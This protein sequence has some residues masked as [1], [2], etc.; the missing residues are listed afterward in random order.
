MNGKPAAGA[1]VT[2]L[3]A[4]TDPAANTNAGKFFCFQLKRWE[5]GLAMLLLSNDADLKAVA[6]QELARPTDDNQRI[7]VGDSWFAMTK[8]GG[9][10]SEKYAMM[11]RAQHWYITAKGISGV[12]KERITQ[13]LAEIDKALPLDPDN[14]DYDSLTPTQWDKL[15]GQI[16]VVQVRVDRSGP[17]MTLKPGERIRVVPHPSDTW[18]CQSWVGMT[19]TTWSGTDITRTVR[20]GAGDAITVFFSFT[21]PYSNFRFGALL[22]QVDRGDIQNCGIVSG[23]GNLWMLPNRPGGKNSGEIRIKLVPVDDE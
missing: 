15:K 20:D 16:K 18:T 10:S 6:E 11:A 8:K 13:R 1:I 23:P 19:T 21:V 14:L 12:V 3:D 22:T 17:M 2:L 7:Q 5:Q 4:P 9:P